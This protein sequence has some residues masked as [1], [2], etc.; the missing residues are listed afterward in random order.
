MILPTTVDDHLRRLTAGVFE[1]AFFLIDTESVVRE[2]GGWLDRY[3]LDDLR[4]NRRADEQLWF[5][6]GVLPLDGP[7]PLVLPS[8]QISEGRPTHIHLI[9]DQQGTWVL[10]IDASGEHAQ[11]QLYQQAVNR[12]D[13]FRQRGLDEPDRG[14]AAHEDIFLTALASLGGV[15]VEHQRGAA[16]AIRSEVQPW[17]GEIYPVESGCVDFSSSPFLV[18]FL[19]HAEGVWTD[20]SIDQLGSGMWTE[21]TSGGGEEHLEATALESNGRALLLLRRRTDEHD[22]RQRMLQIAREGSLRFDR[23]VKQTRNNEIL[24]HCIVHDLNGPLTG[25]MGFLD[26]LGLQD[27]SPK[28]DELV[29]LALKQ[30]LAQQGMIQ[31]ILDAFS[32]E[33]ES[34]RRVE[35]DPK[36][37]PD[38]LEE[39]RTAVETFRPVA[40]SNQ[41][42]LVLDAQAGD[43][44]T[45]KVVGEASRLQRILA[46]LI[47]NALRHSPPESRVRLRLRR[48]GH[49]IYC[50]V[51]DEGDGV[52]TALADSLFE[53]LTKTDDGGGKAGLGLFF[54]RITVELWGGE[55]GFRPIP[56][57]GT[58]FWFRLEAADAKALS[59][60][61]IDGL[62]RG[63][64]VLLVEDDEVNRE[65]VKEMLTSSGIEVC[66][67]ADG[68]AAL[69][70]ADAETVD[71][72]L[73][74]IHLPKL[75]GFEV[76]TRLR[77]ERG[78]TR[79][80]V[81][82][83]T[84]DESVS[85]GDTG[86]VFDAVIS[87]PFS[88]DR[89]Q[90]VLARAILEAAEQPDHGDKPPKDRGEGDSIRL[91]GLD[92]ERT[93]ERLGGDSELLRRILGRFE[94]RCREVAGEL[95]ELVEDDRM[96]DVGGLAHSLKGTAAN[97][98][99]IGVEKAAA[100]LEMGTGA[101]T[102]DLRAMIDD[103]RR[104]VRELSASLRLLGVG[105]EDL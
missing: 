33:V 47:D 55:I 14:D 13:L 53:K 29:K 3:G 67:A 68:L 1:P 78:L 61:Q 105:E 42:G 66:E 99:A 30:A 57:G 6:E 49:S 79:Q 101:G 58:N 8:V 32:P 23:F 54:C 41:I 69:E 95:R 18:D 37:A 71:A 75:G 82:A 85:E 26:L 98:G 31:G 22:E 93:L 5:L 60:E 92:I 10:L 11:Q 28:A 35:R 100:R 16:F 73:L 84:G 64:R 4:V 15:L 34:M 36:S 88:V 46:N 40:Q 24:V 25:M 56:S 94:G 52:P 38:L 104:A 89:L 86:S 7:E 87:K 70:A 19:E 9:P 65:L 51:E 48:E 72:V 76:A 2:A 81:I 17:L 103:L 45:W 90:S 77:A 96:S 20:R 80:P 102:D 62:L 91:P 59:P 21:V 44:S 27:L 12:R 63:A 74:D 97:I 43:A 83:L 39:A 50:N